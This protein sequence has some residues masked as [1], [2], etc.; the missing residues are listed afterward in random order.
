MFS[1][2]DLR[3]IATRA[4]GHL[5]DA[6]Y[7]DPEGKRMPDINIRPDEH[8]EVR[9]EAMVRAPIK[10]AKYEW[11]QERRLIIAGTTELVHGT[12]SG[13]EAKPYVEVPLGD[14]RPAHIVVAAQLGQTGLDAVRGLLASHGWSGVPVEPGESFST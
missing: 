11:E 3:T 2:E 14:V 6:L 1:E 9:L 4:H 13:D 8:C 12:S 10:D 5:R 7:V